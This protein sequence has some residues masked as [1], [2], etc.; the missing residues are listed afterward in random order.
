MVEIQTRENSK[1]PNFLKSV[2]SELW[3]KYHV[4]L[5]PLELWRSREFLVQIF[6]PVNGGERMTVN[7]TEI[8]ETGAWKQN[9]SWDDLM[10]LKTQCGR[11]DRWAVEIYPPDEK[12]VNVA[13]MRH[14]WLVEEAP[15]FAWKR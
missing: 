6:K 12:I 10:K 15:S 4:M 5:R 8:D 1:W 3:P 14:V 11:H 2:P 13:N 7:R 9:I